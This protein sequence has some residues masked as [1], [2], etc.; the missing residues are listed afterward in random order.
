MQVTTKRAAALAATA[1][2]TATLLTAAWGMTTG[3]TE[4][5]RVQRHVDFWN[6]D[7]NTGEK[8]VNYSP[9]VAPED[10]ARLY[11]PAAAVSHLSAREAP[12]DFWNYDPATGKKIANYSP[13][14]AAHDL[15]RLWSGSG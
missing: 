9:G 10:L 11:A 15:A 13:G 5:A 7:A 1:L 14:V 4:P 8:I 2:G 3:S 12:P 6:Y